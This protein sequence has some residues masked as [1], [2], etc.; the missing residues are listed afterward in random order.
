M[1]TSTP[2]GDL[3]SALRQ[4]SLSWCVLCGVMLTWGVLSNDAV[5]AATPAESQVSCRV[6]EG[7][8]VCK[9]DMRP[10]LRNEIREVLNNG[11]E[12][13]LRVRLYLEDESRDV[14]TVSFA[15]LTER[16]YIDLFDNYC[17]AVWTGR[18]AYMRFKDVDAL[19]EGVGHFRL[20]LVPAKQLL[21]D[22]YTARVEVELNPITDEQIN[23][24]RSWLARNRGG[25]LVV[26]QNDASMFGTFIS[27]FAN[28]RP[29][30]AEAYMSLRSPPLTI[31]AEDEVVEDVPSPFEEE[32]R[33]EKTDGQSGWSIPGLWS[34]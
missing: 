26:G 18:D 32:T 10:F 5:H 1:I 8:V 20:E 19:I 25:H 6:E 16:C 2:Y 13:V 7:L 29:G 27:I 24:V 3:I 28:I 33:P 34:W 14:V 4:R 22:R 21:P 9:I 15:E 12:N 31:G 17:L 11:W 30:D 23:I